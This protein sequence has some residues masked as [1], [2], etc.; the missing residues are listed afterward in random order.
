M[1]SE[2]PPTS[3]GKAIPVLFYDFNMPSRDG[4][5]WCMGDDWKLSAGQR[6]LFGCQGDDVMAY[7]HVVGWRRGSDDRT[8]Q[9][10]IRMDGE[11]FY[12]SEQP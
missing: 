1:I 5:Y 9:W 2:G 11:V 3:G 4:L 7:G 12:P 6:V 10:G 8:G